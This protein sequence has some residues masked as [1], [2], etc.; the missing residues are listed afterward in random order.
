MTASPAAS[1]PTSGI[2]ATAELEARPGRLR[3]RERP[4]GAGSRALHRG[5]PERHVVVLGETRVTFADHPL[6]VAD[7]R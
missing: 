4:P 7:E 5:T 2:H 6:G 3:A 1:R